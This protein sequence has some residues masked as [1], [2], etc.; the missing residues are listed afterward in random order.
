MKVEPQFSNENCSNVT[1]RVVKNLCFLN[2][3]CQQFPSKYVPQI[4]LYIATIW[5]A[6]IAK[7]VNVYSTLQKATGRP[8]LESWQIQ[9]V[10]EMFNIKVNQHI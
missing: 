10:H 7:A 1:N 2:Y 5:T 3:P 4:D 9:L 6:A 8:F